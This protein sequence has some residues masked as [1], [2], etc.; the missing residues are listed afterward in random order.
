MRN[1]RVITPVSTNLPSNRCT[2]SSVRCVVKITSTSIIAAKEDN[3]KN[4]TIYH[5]ERSFGV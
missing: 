3:E 2:L 5:C 4:V 1:E